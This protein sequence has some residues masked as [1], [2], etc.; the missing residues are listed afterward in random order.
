MNARRYIEVLRSELLPTFELHGCSHFMQDSAPCHTANVV[1]RFLVN[2]GIETIKWPGNSP[3]LNPIENAWKILKDKIAGKNNITVPAVQKAVM[4]V[5]NNE[6]DLE[7][8]QA[9]S[10][11]MPRRI[12]RVIRAKGY[13]TKY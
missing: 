13:A 1:K 7:Y 9:L 10:D 5:W 2:N 12:R 8:F 3:D 6:M 11:S 4:E